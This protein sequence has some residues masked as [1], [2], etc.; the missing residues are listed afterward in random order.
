MKAFQ[1]I[2][3]SLVAYTLLL[4]AFASLGTFAAAL[5]MGSPL[6]ALAA[7][8]LVACLTGSV[9]GFRAGARKLANA[10]N[11]TAHDGAV[12]IFS[13]PIPSDE[14]DGYLK[15][16]RGSNNASPAGTN[17]TVLAGDESAPQTLA[18]P[19]PSRLSA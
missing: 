4:L 11:G 7:V 14:I 15:R 2:S 9:I 5:A 12:S 10:T 17:M 8:V 18:R 19:T 6:A 13:M 16:Y 1:G 3:A